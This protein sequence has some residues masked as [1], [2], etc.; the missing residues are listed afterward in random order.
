MAYQ[1]A[2][3]VSPPTPQNNFVLCNDVLTS[4]F[5]QKY[6]VQ[7]QHG[8]DIDLVNNSLAIVP[9]TRLALMGF[10]SVALVPWISATLWSGATAEVPQSHR[11]NC[12]GSAGHFWLT[13]LNL[14]VWESENVEM[15]R[16]EIRSAQNVRRV[17]ISRKQTLPILFG[18]ISI[19][20]SMDQP[21]AK[22]YSLVVQQAPIHPVWDSTL[23]SLMWPLAAAS[24]LVLRGASASP[25][26]LAWLCRAESSLL[27][28][29]CS[30]LRERKNSFRRFDQT[31]TAPSILA[32]FAGLRLKN[33]PAPCVLCMPQHR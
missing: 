14:E 27:L 23:L 17:L 5:L 21:H 9:H 6:N 7:A 16:M 2:C 1:Q 24:T 3:R 8:L 13:A 15:L 26:S 33:F 29:R 19:N 22:T 32:R 11:G 10:S 25:D 28:G 12:T 18:A 20:L 31:F 4:P 30:S